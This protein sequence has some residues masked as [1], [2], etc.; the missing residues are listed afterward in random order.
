[1][2]TVK[3][4]SPTSLQIIK[5][6]CLVATIYTDATTE[7]ADNPAG[8]TFIFDE[9][10]RDTTTITQDEN[11]STTIENEFSDDP[12]MEIVSLGK[13][14][15]AAEVADVQKDVL[16]SF[17]NYTYDAAAKKL[18]APAAYIKKYVKIDLV[19]KNGT[20]SEGNDKY[21]S[22]CIPKLQLNSRLMVESMNTNLM[23]LNLAGTAKSI[24]LT[25]NGKTTKSAAYINEDFKMPTETE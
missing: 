8:D 10:V 9:V 7:T 24:A 19:F 5:P 23:R 11:E 12:I 2:A 13:F 14:Q 20:D 25:V 21:M 15:F 1:M 18:F 6:D 4:T 3:R 17:A 22:V 16:T